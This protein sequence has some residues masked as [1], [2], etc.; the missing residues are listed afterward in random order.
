MAINL[1]QNILAS[2]IEKLSI[3]EYFVPESNSEKACFQVLCDFN[4]IAGKVKS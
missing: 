1:D 4:H 2:I 3:G